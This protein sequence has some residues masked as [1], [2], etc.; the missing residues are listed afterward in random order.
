MTYLFIFLTPL[1]N[2]FLFEAFFFRPKLFYIALIVSSLLIMLAVR[3]ITGKKINQRDFWNFSIL[4]LLFSGVIAAYS[5][6]ITNHPFIHL[7]FILNLLSSL[8]YLKNIYQGE[9]SE[10][11]ENFSSYGN[12]L[13]AFFSFS[14]IYGLKTFLN[15]PIWIL[16]IA[17]AAVIILIIYQIFWANGVAVKANIFFIF[18]A[19]LIL[20][21]LAWALYF[22]PFSYNVLGLILAICYYMQI[23]LIKL[24][25][26]QKLT[27]RNIKLYLISGLSGI[28]LI[29]LT[30]KWI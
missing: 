26:S 17:A 14:A 9:R 15:V 11:L 20:T 8:Y 23:G 1:L 22:L 4:P 18:I 21:Q 5:L 12:F 3:K 27:I 2:F 10:F 16:I 30:A 7:L 13:I 28:F 19:C 25:L 29:L 6:I 24:C